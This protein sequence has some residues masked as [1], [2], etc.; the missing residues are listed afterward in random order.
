M[1]G[2]A[3]GEHL[4]YTCLAFKQRSKEH[5][6]VRW[7]AAACFS[8]VDTGGGLETRGTDGAPHTCWHILGGTGGEPRGGQIVPRVGCNISVRVPELK[9]VEL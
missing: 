9:F 3:I 4:P 1:L 6:G 5:F 7:H 2:G 8:T